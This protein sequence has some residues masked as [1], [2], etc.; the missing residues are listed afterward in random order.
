[1]RHVVHLGDKRNKHYILCGKPEGNIRGIDQNTDNNIKT[2]LK[3]M[4]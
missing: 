3:V 4:V 2:V 1:V